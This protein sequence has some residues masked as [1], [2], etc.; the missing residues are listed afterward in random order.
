MF[1]PYQELQVNIPVIYETQPGISSLDGDFVVKLPIT[2]EEACRAGVDISGFPKFQA[3]VDFEE[4]RDCRR[5]QVKVDEKDLIMLEVEKV[6]I[7][8]R[9]WIW[10]LYSVIDGHLLRTPFQNSGQWGSVDGKTGASFTLGT[11][12]IAREI[13]C[14]AME[15]TPIRH[16]YACHLSSILQ[17]PEKL[18]SL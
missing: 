8:S 4:K 13:A 9:T 5:C 10:Y 6:P 16:E 3:S 11:H 7:Q 14:L 1:G 12:P 15:P 2:S 17:P 18:M